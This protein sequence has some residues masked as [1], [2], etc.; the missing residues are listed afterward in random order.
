M[1]QNNVV[2]VGLIVSMHFQQF[3]DHKVQSF[4]KELCP[5]TPLSPCVFGTA[6]SIIPTLII[7]SQFLK[8]APPPP[9]KKNSGYRP[10]IKCCWSFKV[11]INNY[12]F[13]SF[14][15]FLRHESVHPI[16][17]FFGQSINYPSSPVCL[18]SGSLFAKNGK[19]G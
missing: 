3:E 11:T 16:S 19:Q 6:W 10:G 7:W 18:L 17:L 8:Y 15:N 1:I 5:R 12:I 14:T 2:I 9:S 4:L 13:F